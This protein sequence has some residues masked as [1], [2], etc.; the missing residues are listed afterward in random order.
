M[1]LTLLKCEGV[2]QLII[3]KLII[4]IKLTIKLMDTWGIVYIQYLIK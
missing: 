1:Q 3:I 4:I 2:L